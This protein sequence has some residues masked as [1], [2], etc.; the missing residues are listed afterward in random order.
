MTTQHKWTQAWIATAAAA[1]L[2]GLAGCSKQEQAELEAKTDQAKAEMHAKADAAGEKIDQAQ[3]DMSQ[4]LDDTTITT[5]VK[6][7]FAESPAVSALAI[8][9]ETDQ[10]VVSLTGTVAT[11]V[12]RIAAESLARSVADVRDVK[13]NLVVKS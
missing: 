9:V 2:L 1:G 12:E 11:E 13:N 10:G 8:S 6:T 7:A 3:T 4:A 5:R